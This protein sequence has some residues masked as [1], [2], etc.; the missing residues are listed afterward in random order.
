MKKEIIEKILENKKGGAFIR[1]AYKTEPPMKAAAKGLYRVEKYTISTFKCKTN[2]HNVKRYIAKQ[3]ERVEPVKP[4][5]PWAR[6][7]VPNVFLQNIKSGREYLSL[8]TLPKNSNTR[9]EYIVYNLASGEQTKVQK[10]E[11]QEMGIVLPSYW[12]PSETETVNIPIENI[13]NIY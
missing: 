7:T 1:V 6:W 11:L 3:A 2:L 12:N 9:N 10:S 13:I 5:E 8:I 4:R